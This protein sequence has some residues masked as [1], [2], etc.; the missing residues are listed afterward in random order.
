[1]S[2]SGVRLISI[3]AH[4]KGHWC[5]EGLEVADCEDHIAKNDESMKEET[6]IRTKENGE[7]QVHSRL[8]KSFSNVFRFS[9]RSY[10]SFS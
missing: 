10:K 7:Y 9:F 1:M 3:C 6:G 4:R 8:Q 2:F 5:S